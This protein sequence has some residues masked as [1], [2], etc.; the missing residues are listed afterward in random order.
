MMPL[1]RKIKEKEKKVFKNI[2]TFTYILICT[3]LHV[4][5]LFVNINTIPLGNSNSDAQY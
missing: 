4:A 1:I 3:F 2:F 5:I